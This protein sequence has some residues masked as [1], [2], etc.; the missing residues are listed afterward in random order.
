MLVVAAV[1]MQVSWNVIK[2]EGYLKAFVTLPNIA[3]GNMISNGNW[4]VDL[5]DADKG[6]AKSQNRHPNRYGKRYSL[7]AK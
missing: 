5:G 2:D 7:E 4:I 3:L 1:L 6:K